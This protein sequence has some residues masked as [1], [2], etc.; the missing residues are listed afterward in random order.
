M[1]T[2]HGFAVGWLVQFAQV[3]N[4]DGAVGVAVSVTVVPVENCP[5]HAGAPHGE[6]NPTGL[7]TTVPSPVP[8]KVTVRV[9]DP[10]VP[11]KQIT[12][13]VIEPVTIV[14][15]EEIPPALVLV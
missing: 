11:E 1:V 7:L 5:V 10:V 6:A 15:E 2:E 4:V 3:P 12:L 13:P 14:P 9:A 8:A